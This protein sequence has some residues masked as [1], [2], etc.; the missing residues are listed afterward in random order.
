M[1]IMNQAM[2]LIC[3]PLQCV[4]HPLRRLLPQGCPCRTRAAKGVKAQSWRC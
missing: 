2:S 4:Q 1:M 3:R